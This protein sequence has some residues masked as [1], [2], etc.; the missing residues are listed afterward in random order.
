M[1]KASTPAAGETKPTETTP[2]RKFCKQIEALISR[3]NEVLTED[4]LA[5]FAGVPVGKQPALLAKIANSESA[6][7]DSIT[8]V[9]DATELKKLIDKG[10]FAE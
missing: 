6:D 3:E 2:K 8:F 4:H 9:K 5:L 7:P 1:A 10:D